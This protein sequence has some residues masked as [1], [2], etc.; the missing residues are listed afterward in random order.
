MPLPFA[1]EKLYEACKKGVLADVCTALEVKGGGGGGIDVNYRGDGGRTPLYW[2]STNGHVDIVRHLLSVNGIQ[3]NQARDDGVT[4]LIMAST[5][6]HVDVV[7]LLL[8]AE[9]VEVNQAD[10]NGF[11]ALIMASTKGHV[12][13]VRLL[14]GAEGVEVNQA[15]NNG[16]TAL[17]VASNEGHVD[18]VRLLLGAEGVE[19]NQAENNGF[20][21]LIM[22]QGHVDV[23]RLLLGAEGVEVNQASNDGCTALIM[24]SQNGHVDYVRLLLGAEGVEVNQAMNGGYTALILA[25]N[26]G[27]VDVV[28]LLLGAEGVEVNQ[29]SNDGAT[30]LI[31]ASNKGHVEV[32]RL[33]KAKEHEWAYGTVDSIRPDATRDSNFE[34]SLS[35][36]SHIAVAVGNTSAS[37][38]DRRQ[39]AATL[40][41]MEKKTQPFFACCGALTVLLGFA[42]CGALTVLLGV[43]SLNVVYSQ[44]N[45]ARSGVAF[46]CGV[47]VNGTFTHNGATEALKQSML[48]W[49]VAIGGPVMAA[50]ILGLVYACAMGIGGKIGEAI[51]VGFGGALGTPFAIGA[52]GLCCWVVFGPLWIAN[53]LGSDVK[54]C[55][56]ETAY[57]GRCC[58]EATWAIYS[59]ALYTF[60]SLAA[61]MFFL[62]KE[63]AENAEKGEME[64]FYGE[65]FCAGLVFV[66]QVYG[67]ASAY[68]DNISV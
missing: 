55:G 7:R 53:V 13:V 30:A 49:N 29:A 28:R 59:G 31:I 3:V 5:K 42:C 41:S 40:D 45:S 54:Y 36:T 37:R 25:S 62:V 23:V 39:Q 32:T 8:G 57:G 44:S 46:P 21:A 47:D 17:I 6:G 15:S 33:L 61:T 50:V 11:T 10:N 26:E 2:A 68:M 48:S 64:V 16:C 35:S 34:I 12:D 38:R 60:A 27:H 56:G 51:G 19:V 20:T 1:N 24:A 4:A 43:I 66:L 9:G 67:V 52:I 58:L 65:F 14:L 63:Y 18:V 22:D